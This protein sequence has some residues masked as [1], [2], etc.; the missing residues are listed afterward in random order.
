MRRDNEDNFSDFN[1]ASDS[2]SEYS[3][4]SDDTINSLTSNLTY[5]I[6]EGKNKLKA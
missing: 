2:N 3:R 4:V 5:R 1:S 6:K